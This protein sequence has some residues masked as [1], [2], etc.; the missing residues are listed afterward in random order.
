MS[1]ANVEL[2]RRG[3]AAIV[4]GDFSAIGDLLH[5]DV[6]WH[7]GDPA[8]GCQNRDETLHFM[9]QAAARGGAGRLVDVI[10]AGDRVVVVLEPRDEDGGVLPL[11]ANV[12][13]FRDGR[14][15]EMVAYETPQAARAAVGLPA[16]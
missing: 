13:T 1:S 11:Q 7:G 8:S 2:A 15:A 3:Y 16:D 12:T 6:R 9:R 10:D 5:D 4:A 14:V